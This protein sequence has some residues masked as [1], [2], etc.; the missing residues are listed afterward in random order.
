ME[1]RIRDFIETKDGPI[2]SVVSYF[3]PPD[4]YI[5]FLRYYPD[6]K[7]ERQRGG[8]RYKKISSTRESYEFLEKNFSEYLFFSDIAG[9]RIQCVPKGKI[10]NIRLPSDVL[11]EI[12]E[13]PRGSYEEK[14]S[15]LSDIFNSIPQDRKGITGSALVG[16]QEKNSDIDFVIYGTKNHEKA[17]GILKEELNNKLKPLT[18]KQWQE[19]YRKRFPLG[20]ALDF[21]EFLWHENR[22]FH[23]GT[24]GGTIFDIL[25]VRDFGEIQEKYS[26]KKFRRDGPI[27]AECRVVDATFAYDSPA[28]YKVECKDE[29]IEVASFTHTYAGQAFEGEKI[30]V[31]GFLEE[32]SGRENYLRIV[33][34]TTREAEGEYIKVK[35]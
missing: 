13:N 26:D 12:C 34:G 9:S 18:K 22:K 14:I 33:V 7:G 11:K 1:P 19:V 16:L 32:V 3:H 21:E 28:I 30:E 15:Q 31:S 27:K 20:G 6:E 2:F 5:A 10:S 24:I 8:A 23:K 35:K 29:I 17:R 4:R 25:L